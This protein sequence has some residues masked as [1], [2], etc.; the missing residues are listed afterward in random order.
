MIDKNPG[1]NDDKQR[2]DKRASDDARDT[3]TAQLKSKRLAKE[4]ADREQG[5][6]AIP[7]GKLNASN[8]T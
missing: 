7:V 2:A 4:T 3:K 1:F 5:D 8:D 6:K